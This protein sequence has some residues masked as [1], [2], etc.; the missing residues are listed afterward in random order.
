MSPVRFFFVAACLALPVGA[1]LLEGLPGK[2][3]VPVVPSAGSVGAAPAPAPA[4]VDS[5]AG[6]NWLSPPLHLQ[7]SRDPALNTIGKGALFL[8]TYSE[9]RREPEIAVVNRTGTLVATGQT[10]T[11]IQLD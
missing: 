4:T 8:P 10:G 9:S 5:Q 7:L 1:A 11:R 2:E 3:V 6:V